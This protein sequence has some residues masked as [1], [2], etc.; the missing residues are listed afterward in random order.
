LI[1]FIVAFL[2]NGCTYY[3]QR[4][5]LGAVAGAAT[6]ALVADSTA[7]HYGGYRQPFY[8]GYGYTNHYSQ[9]PPPPLRVGS[10]YAHIRSN[11]D[12][13]DAYKWSRYPR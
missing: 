3:E 11:R 13:Y 6:G 4:V 10:P 12:A 9:T 2:I 8:S 5:A 1:G 7:P